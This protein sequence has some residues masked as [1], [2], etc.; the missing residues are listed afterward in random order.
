MLGRK[1]GVAT[2]LKKLFPALFIWHC[3][4]HRLELA[5]SDTRNEVLDVNP[6][7]MFFDK[8]YSVYSLS[9]KNQR[10]LMACPATL[11]KGLRKV[12]KIFT[13]RWVAS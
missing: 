2:E 7:H 11:D 9:P 3:S 13:I 12:S 10:E 5:V 6:F 4:N 8:L 1:A